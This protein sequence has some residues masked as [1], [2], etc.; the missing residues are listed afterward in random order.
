MTSITVG[1]E[2]LRL[3]LRAV[4]PHADPDPEFPQLHRVRL[5][6]G[7]ENLTVSATNRYTIGHAIVSIWENQ[8]GDLAAFD[9]S[10]SDVR[11]ILA[12]FRSTKGHTDDMPDDTLLLEVDDHH[13]TVTDVSG[14]FPGKSLRLPKYPVEE[15]FPNVAVLI[16]QGLTRQPAGTERLITNGKLLGLFGKA[17]AA[18]NEQLVMDTSGGNAAIL[19]TCGESFVGMLM[20]VKGDEDTHARIEGWHTDWLERLTELPVTTGG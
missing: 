4:A 15:N 18:Y 9:L 17:A 16:K 12:L 7:P 20:P 2:D 14:L 13:A 1:T 19:I 11:E 3:A 8:M 5:A 6:V 10:P